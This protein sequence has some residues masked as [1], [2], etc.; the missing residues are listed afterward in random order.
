VL[1]TAR[2]SQRPRTTENLENRG[3][4]ESNGAAMWEYE[5]PNFEAAGSLPVLSLL[6]PE[7]PTQPQAPVNPGDARRTRRLLDIDEIDTVPPP[8]PQAPPRQQVPFTGLEQLAAQPTTPV[9][10][11]TRRLNDPANPAY[12]ANPSLALVP[13]PA[14]PPVQAFVQFSPAQESALPM[15][16]EHIPPVAQ[17]DDASWT[18]GLASDSPYARLIAQPASR[19]LRLVNPIDSLRWWLLRPGRIEFAMWLSGSLL[20]VLVTCA[21]LFA[22][23]FSF[24]TFIPVSPITHAGGIAENGASG[25]NAHA[26]LSQR[27]MLGTTGQIVPGE[28]VVVR[29]QGF[30]HNGLVKF[31]LDGTIT[32]FD[33]HA[34]SAQTTANA[35]GNFD[36]VLWLGVGGKWSLGRHIIVALDVRTGQRA[37]LP[38]T[39]ANGP[40][41]SS[42]IAS[43][44]NSPVAPGGTSTSTSSSS[45]PGVTQTA[46]PTHTPAPQGTPVNKTPVPTTPTPSPSPAH[47]PTATPTAG[48]TPTLTPTVSTS[49]TATAGTSSGTPSS[50]ATSNAGLSNALNQSGIPPISTPFVIVSPLVWIMVGCYALSMILLGVAGLLTRRKRSVVL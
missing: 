4:L 41:K 20:L 29:G 27:L 26:A 35:Q 19:G 7:A 45:A 36:M 33:A 23:A 34:R 12:P 48:V 31:Y 49:P 43:T 25:A 46:V 39:L 21:L 5:S 18:A 22:F 37:A 1:P 9:G 2:P 32:M 28:Q 8:Q 42:T 17:Q 14:A 40:T 47:T 15:V 3:I 6:A 50:T 10:R 44:S 30:S 13:A 11:V 38:I 24:P 16:V